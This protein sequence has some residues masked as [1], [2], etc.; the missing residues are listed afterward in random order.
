MSEYKRD[1]YSYKS[2]DG[3]DW[4]IT[5]IQ[6]KDRKYV[7]VSREGDDS[8]KVAWDVDML[9]DIADV[10]RLATSPSKPI[11]RQSHGLKKPQIIDHRE[12]E[13][14]ETVDGEG[15]RSDQIQASVDESLEKEIDAGFVPSASL[16][17]ESIESEIKRRQSK[18]D[19]LQEKKINR[20]GVVPG[21][22][23]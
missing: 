23:I 14:S 22:L 21:D 7:E 3:E 6:T 2:P 4:E 5:V 1:D 16:S 18:K 13:E 20:A 17:K 8:D 12:S 11:A 19:V 10:A 15:S 9:L